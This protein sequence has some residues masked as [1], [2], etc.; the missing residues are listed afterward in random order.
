MLLFKLLWQLIPL[1]NRCID[2]LLVVYSYRRGRK[3]EQL[4]FSLGKL[5]RKLILP[6]RRKK[7]KKKKR[8]QKK[9]IMYQTFFLPPLPS[10][11][12]FPSCVWPFSSLAVNIFFHIRFPSFSSSFFL[13]LFPANYNNNQKL[14]KTQLITLTFIRYISSRKAQNSTDQWVSFVCT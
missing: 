5:G 6:A 11:F 1:L 4:L 2:T 7:G 3:K 12:L 9:R 13:S 10:S 8:S 14:M